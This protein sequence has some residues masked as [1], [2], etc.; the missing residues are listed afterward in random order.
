MAVNGSIISTS[1]KCLLK[2]S[3]RISEVLNSRV[4][5]LSLLVTRNYCWT[6]RVLGAGWQWSGVEK[7]CRSSPLRRKSL[8]KVFDGTQLAMP[9]QSCQ[10]LPTIQICEN[11][12]SIFSCHALQANQK[13]LQCQSKSYLLV[14]VLPHLLTLPGV[15]KP[16]KYIQNCGFGHSKSKTIH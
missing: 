14:T 1:A 7:T 15:H 3:V 5:L 6:K 9:F 8:F 4:L 13:L 2:W 16:P 11:K 10:A 12:Y